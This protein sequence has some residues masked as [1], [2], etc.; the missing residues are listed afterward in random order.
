MNYADINEV[1][2]KKQN[3]RKQVVG[4]EKMWRKC[5]GRVAEMEIFD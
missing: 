1:G 3:S 5:R 2:N 4:G